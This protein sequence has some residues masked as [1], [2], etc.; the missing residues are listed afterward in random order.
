LVTVIVVIAAEGAVASL[1]MAPLEA[2]AFAG[3]AFVAV[4]L[5]YPVGAFLRVASDSASMRH[6]SSD[7]SGL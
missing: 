4:Q 1:V 7:A 3:A 6:V 2:A 5:A